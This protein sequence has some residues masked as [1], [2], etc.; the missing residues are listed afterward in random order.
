MSAMTLARCLLGI[1][2]VIAARAYPQGAVEQ[3]ATLV[4][5]NRTGEPIAAITDG[6]LLS[7]KVQLARAVAR[8]TGVTFGLEGASLPAA[9][10]TIASGENTC[11][12]WRCCMLWDGIGAMTAGRDC[13]ARYRR[14]PIR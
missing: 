6:D 1:L 8:P 9:S 5:L 3:G 12:S 11:T 7:L 4:V 10:C 13:A 14:P 2:L